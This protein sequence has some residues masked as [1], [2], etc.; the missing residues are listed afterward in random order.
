M[1]MKYFILILLLLFISCRKG[2]VNY[3]STI[4]L[5]RLE[6]VSY[7]KS[8]KP[9]TMDVEI[10]YPECPG[11]QIEIIRGDKKFTDCILANF[12]KHDRATASILWQWNELGF[13]D[14]EVNKIGPCERKVDKDDE[15]SYDMIEE[16]E[17]Y[18][19]YGNNVGFRC[20]RIA[21]SDLIKKCPWFRRK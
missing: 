10:T 7:D 9:L 3:E 11:D 15:V 6:V 21:T 13:Y 4:E 16:C 2:P 19:V 17:D 12:K 20:K 18:V 14:W 5:N 1:K 8:N